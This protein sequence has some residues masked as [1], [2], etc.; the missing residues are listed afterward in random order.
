MLPVGIAGAT[1][2]RGREPTVFQHRGP[3]TT[4]D[5]DAHGIAIKVNSMLHHRACPCTLSL[6]YRSLPLLARR[7]SRPGA[8]DRLRLGGRWVALSGA[9]E[10]CT[11]A[12]D[13]PAP[14]P[15]GL[16]LPRT[17][18]LLHGLPSGLPALCA[19]G[20]GRGYARWHRLGR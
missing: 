20:R 17:R 18:R 13:W 12:K 15:V 4:V 11:V 10:D 16:L 1:L 14:R 19:A 6:R 9:I 5:R 8:S 2:P 3:G 7:H